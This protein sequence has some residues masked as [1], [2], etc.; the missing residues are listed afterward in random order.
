MWKDPNSKSIYLNVPK[1]TDFCLCVHGEEF[2]RLV[3]VDDKWIKHTDRVRI[4]CFSH[5][6][7]RDHEA[8]PVIGHYKNMIVINAGYSRSKKDALYVNSYLIG[9]VPNKGDAIPMNTP[10]GSNVFV[11]PG[12]LGPFNLALSI[13][14]KSS[15]IVGKYRCSDTVHQLADSMSDTKSRSFKAILESLHWIIDRKAPLDEV[16]LNVSYKYGIES[17]ELNRKV[18][19]HMNLA[20]NS[21][22]FEP[23]MGVSGPRL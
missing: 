16:M 7:D 6:K 20:T 18:H 8:E 10:I 13:S 19:Q 2:G 12:K 5:N 11:A 17:E 22:E 21:M 23:Q 14:Q 3:R 4:D 1:I 9:F 15:M